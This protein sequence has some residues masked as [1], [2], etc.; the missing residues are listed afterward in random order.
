MISQ[1]FLSEIQK[2]GF[3]ELV[4]VAKI[5]ARRGVPASHVDVAKVVMSLGKKKFRRAVRKEISVPSGDPNY[6]K[7]D[8]KEIQLANKILKDIPL[9]A[10]KTSAQKKLLKKVTSGKGQ[11]PQEKQKQLPPSVS[12]ELFSLQPEMQP[13]PNNGIE[14]MQ[15]S[16]KGKSA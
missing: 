6:D 16:P 4:D 10:S 7:Q 9:E 2:V 12:S 8:K 15:P 13:Q 3:E 5:V 1:G 14:G 11:N